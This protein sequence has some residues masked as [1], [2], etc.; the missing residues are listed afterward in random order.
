MERLGHRAEL[1]TPPMGCEAAMP[2]TIAV[3]ASSSRSRRARPAEGAC[4]PG[5]VP[6][7]V[8]AATARRDRLEAHIEAA[9]PPLIDDPST[10][11]KA[12]WRGFDVPPLGFGE[13]SRNE[14]GR[15]RNDASLPHRSA[16]RNGS[17][18]FPRT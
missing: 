17:K 12:D 10:K 2:N 9:R 5:D 3:C 1:L 6:A 13:R 16:H 4:G 7:A 15:P 14:T 11:N 8:E 18:G